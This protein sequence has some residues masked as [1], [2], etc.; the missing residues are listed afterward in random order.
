MSRDRFIT[1]DKRRPSVADVEKV[2][3]Q[4]FGPDV[5]KVEWNAT[6]RRFYV[7]LRG[8]WSH[9]LRGVMAISPG[10]LE[11][12]EYPHDLRSIEVYVASAEPLDVITRHADAFTNASADGL[13]SQL[14]YGWG[15]TIEKG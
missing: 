7:T 3:T 12:G 4:Y 8:R 10:E 13:A 15:G 6:Q 2:I 11:W 14:A 5:A 1:Y 9:P